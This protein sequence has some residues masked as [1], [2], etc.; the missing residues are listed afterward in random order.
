MEGHGTYDVPPGTWSDDSALTL[1]QAQALCHIEDSEDEA[2]ART[3]DYI[4]R[5]YR[6]EIWRTSG[7]QFD[8]G[9]TID[10]AIQRLQAGT[11][12]LEAGER[13][14]RSNG[15]GS[16]I[17]ILPLAFYAGH[18]DFLELLERV[19]QASCLTHAHPRSQIACGI[20][21]SIAVELLGEQPAAVAYVKSLERLQAFYQTE[22]YRHQ[23]PHFQRIFSGEIDTLA[24]S[25]LHSDGYVVNMLEIALWCLLNS[26]S[27]SEAILTAINLGEDTDTAGAVTGGLAGLQFGAKDIPLDWMQ[28]VAHFYQIFDLSKRLEAALAQTAPV[29]SV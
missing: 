22:P 14:E 5:W 24:A 9:H 19:H 29:H 1:C 18:L 10:T 26:T 20:Y 7:E 27:Y 13:H 25:D 16:L 12:P 8:L 15:S 21:V 11:P 28:R 17:R 6:G 23:L 2:L 3:A 4:C